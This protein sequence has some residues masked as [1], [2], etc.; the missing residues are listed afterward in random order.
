MQ[1]D[2]YR[3]LAGLVRVAGGYAKD[4]TP[5]SEFLWADFFRP[6][7]SARLIADQQSRATRMGV[8]LARSSDARY[9]PGWIGK[10]ASR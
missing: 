6:R 8:K 7:I 3:S 5:F 9:L 1:N 2:P 10:A 4:L